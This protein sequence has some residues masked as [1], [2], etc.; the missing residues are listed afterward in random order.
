MTNQIISADAS[1]I[2]E[3]LYSITVE[4]LIP[5]VAVLAVLWGIKTAVAA[6]RSAFR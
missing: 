2:F 6:F 4:L 3:G 5:V 1:S